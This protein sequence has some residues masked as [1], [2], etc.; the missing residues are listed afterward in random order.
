MPP[1]LLP[2][3]GSRASA[4]SARA[5][6]EAE[7]RRRR[8]GKR[9]PP[10]GRCRGA[11]RALLVEAAG[12]LEIGDAER[13][14]AQ[15]LLH[16]SVPPPDPIGSDPLREALRRWRRAPVLNKSDI[17]SVL[18]GSPSNA[19]GAPLGERAPRGSCA[20]DRH[21]RPR[22]RAP[23]APARAAVAGRR[24]P[25]A[26]AAGAPAAGL[27]TIADPARETPPQLPAR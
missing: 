6:P 21:S 16:G 10:R 25:A 5:R 19:P 13:H 12:S 27:R 8:S 9:R 18:C 20:P 15:T 26:S 24:A 11:S 7:H 4:A 22:R 23:P 17:A 1:K 14:Q 2:A 3:S